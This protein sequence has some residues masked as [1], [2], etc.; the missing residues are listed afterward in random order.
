MPPEKPRQRNRNDDRGDDDAQGSAV[1]HFSNMR[2]CQAGS[3][4]KCQLNE[5]PGVSARNQA[6]IRAE[7][8]A[9]VAFPDSLDT[10]TKANWAVSAKG[11]V[12]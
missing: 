2:F 10:E 4:C 12:L 8:I 5:R 3:S 7:Q 11:E 1:V 6:A 9:L